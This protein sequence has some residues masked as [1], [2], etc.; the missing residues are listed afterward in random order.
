MTYKEFMELANE[1]YENG[2]DTF[3]ECWDEQDFANYEKEFGKMTKKKALQM[4][5][6]QGAIDNE[7]REAAKWASGEDKEEKEMAKKTD[8]K[9]EVIEITVEGIK[10]TSTGKYFYK[11]GQED[12]KWTR[13]SKA[14]WEQKF[15]QYTQE[16]ADAADADE[17]DAEREVEARKQEQEAK[18][19]ATEKAFNKKTSKKTSEKKGL[20]EKQVDFIKHIPDTN[21]YEHGLEST[22]WCDV[23]VEEIG[24][25]FAG[26]PFVVG[27]MISTL[28]EKGLIY[29]TKDR[30]NGKTCKFFGF[31]EEGKKV[32]KELGLN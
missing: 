8:G 13:I 9:A 20:T 4:I 17:W 6:T 32:A 14:E 25:Q 22:M 29:V 10:Y 2:G 19:A 16:A 7:Y 27:A 23:L 26:N 21:F 18:D 11:R 12:E 28:K 15:E 5:K 1:N 3:V 24:G 30:V 31:T